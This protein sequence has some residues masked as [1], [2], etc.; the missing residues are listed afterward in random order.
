[1]VA[2]WLAI[3][4]TSEDD[5]IVRIS[6]VPSMQLDFAEDIPSNIFSEEDCDT[7]GA[8]NTLIALRLCQQRT[9]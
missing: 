3:S 7:F 8:V 6:K 1:V 5:P 9:N 4:M 2:E